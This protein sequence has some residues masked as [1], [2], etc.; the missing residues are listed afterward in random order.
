MDSRLGLSTPSAATSAKPKARA[1]A[2]HAPTR[3]G[4]VWATVDV[5]GNEMSN[6]PQVKCK[7]C[8]VV[9]TAGLTRVTEH[10]T[11]MGSINCC[12]CE[13]DSFLVLKQKLV[14]ETHD[15]REKK[16]Q[17][18]TNDEVDALPDALL[19]APKSETKFSQQGI[20]GA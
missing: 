8:D 18:T 3:T 20:R 15:K 4:P 14:E 13:D 16:K 17:K 2:K 19:G 7:H 11:G 6:T 5:V 1:Q 12:L 10:I 9:F